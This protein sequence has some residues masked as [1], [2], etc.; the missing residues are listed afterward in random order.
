MINPKIVIPTHYNLPDFIH[1]NCN[2]AD[3]QWFKSEVEKLGIKCVIMKLGET[4]EF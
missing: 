1:R 4:I 2:S 3:D